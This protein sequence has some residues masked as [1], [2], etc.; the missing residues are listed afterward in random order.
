MCQITRQSDDNSGLQGV[1]AATLCDW[2]RDLVPPFQPI[3]CILKPS[4]HLRF[5]R[6]RQY[7]RVFYIT[8]TTT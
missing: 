3:S 6:C 1:G 7:I 2:S 5:A 4:G 8:Q